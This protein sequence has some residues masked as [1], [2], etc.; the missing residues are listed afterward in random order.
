ME[1][2][3]A[4]VEAEVEAA[5]LPTQVILQGLAYPGA[6]LTILKDGQ[7]ATGGILADSGGNFKVTLTT[8][9][10]GIYTFSV[11]AEDK[12][13]RR[14]T[15]FSFTATVTSGMTTTISNIFLPPTIELEKTGVKKGEVLNILGQSAPQSEITIKINSPGEIIKTVTTTAGGDWGYPFNTTPLE[16]GVH[17]AKAKANLNGLLSS[18]SNVLVFYVGK[19]VAPGKVKSADLQGDV[20]VN[21]VDFSILLYNWGTPRNTK[22]DINDDGWVNLVDF[23]IMMHQWTG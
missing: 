22:A 11:W 17:F 8:L 16:D 3:E 13:G 15:T 23:S 14:S 4:A 19:E 6:E 10:A 21:L 12:E 2:V 9:T 20:R 7:V 18:Y 5:Q 1:A